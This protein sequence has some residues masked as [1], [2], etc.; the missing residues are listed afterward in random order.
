MNAGEW[1]Y[2]GDVSIRQGGFYWMVEGDGCPARVV[3]VVP[4]S[5]HGG[6]DNVF[7]I[8]S[9]DLDLD[10]SDR[11]SRARAI[12]GVRD[13]EATPESDVVS[14][15]LAFGPSDV[16]EDYTLRI[17]GPDPYWVGREPLAEPEV[18][19]RRGTSLRNW[20]RREYL[21]RPPEPA[22]A[23]LRACA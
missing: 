12:C 7:R 6:P 21:R 17:G 2:F 13:A 1:N 18:V 16:D 19:L 8:M 4:F 11:L 22:P 15:W 10:D 23:P 9:A 3:A 14:L 20:I 5:D